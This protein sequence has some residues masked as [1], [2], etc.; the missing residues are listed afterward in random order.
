LFYAVIT[1]AVTTSFSLSKLKGL[2]YI[3]SLLEN[4]SFTPFADILSPAGIRLL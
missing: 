2:L 3:P 4:V 1:M